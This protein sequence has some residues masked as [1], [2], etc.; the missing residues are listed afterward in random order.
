MTTQDPVPATTDYCNVTLVGPHRQQ[1]P[2]NRKETTASVTTYSDTCL[3]RPVAALSWSWNCFIIAS[4]LIDA[5]A[6]IAPE[7]T[8]ED[9]KLG[10]AVGTASKKPNGK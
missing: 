8:V 6:G 4:A 10:S 9:V 2:P 1:G 5:L 3:S 7:F